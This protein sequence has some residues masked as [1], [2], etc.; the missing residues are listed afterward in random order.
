MKFIQRLFV[1]AALLPMLAVTA[2]ARQVTG[3]AAKVNGSVI[4]INEVNYHL[5]PYRQQLDAA[6]PR[7]GTQYNQLLSKARGEILENLIE[8]ELILSEF[9]HSIKGSIPAHAIDSEIDRQVRELYN[10]SRREFNKSLKEA[11]VT[12]SQHRK[13]TEKKLI[14]Q[15]MRAQQFKNAV[16]PLPSEVQAEY[17]RHKLKM[18]DQSGDAMDYHKIY[19]LKNDPSNALVTPKVQLELA[20]S[21]VDRLKKGEDFATL[22]KEYSADSYAEDGGKIVNQKRTDLSPA[23]ASILME[24]PEGKVLGPLEDGRGFTIVRVDKK[25]YGPV[26]PLSK[27]RKVIESR[28]RARK[29]KAKHDRWMKR[30]RSNAMIQKKI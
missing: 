14:V 19:I 27:V 15:A 20:E 9:K 11:G 7:K 25:R 17:N 16:P 5:T 13:E 30:L 24:T 10:N 29:N 2:D 28:V 18:R 26:P 3:I 6:M 4:T 8:R 22:A 1:I 21:I 23:F 12:P